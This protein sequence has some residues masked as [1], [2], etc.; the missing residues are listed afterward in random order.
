MIDHFSLSEF[1][2]ALPINKKTGARLWEPVG[3]LQGEWVYRIP[4]GGSGRIFITVRSSVRADG[5][6]ADTA[7]DSIRAWL[8]DDRGKALAGK[9]QAYVTRVPG[10]QKRMTD[11]LREL[12]S[13]GVKAG[14]CPHCQEPKR[15]LK[16]HRKDSPNYNRVYAKCWTCKDNGFVWLSD[17]PTAPASSKPAQPELP[18]KVAIVRMPE[19]ND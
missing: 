3:L 18:L 1:E 14:V 2:Q 16:V 5:H 13:W 17:E 6:S 15:I 7:K 12:Y 8:C 19:K 10:W 9:T 11:M 4:V